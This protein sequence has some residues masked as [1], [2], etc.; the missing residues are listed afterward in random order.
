MKKLILL[1]A[2]M[3]LASIAQAR[4]S[5]WEM[6]CAQTA[7]L[8]KNSRGIVMNYGYSDR[9]GFLYKMYY[10][11]QNYCFRTSNT[12][13]VK[14]YA[15]TTDNDRCWVGWECVRDDDEH[16]DHGD[17]GRSGRN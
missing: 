14:A 6:T 17:G 15:K 9:A 16:N 3:L 2:P 4:P 10:P 11:S 12:V 5:T 8:V 7:D 13:A 1:A